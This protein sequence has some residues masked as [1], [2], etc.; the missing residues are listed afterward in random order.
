MACTYSSPAAAPGT[1]HEASAVSLCPA[2]TAPFTSGSFPPMRVVRRCSPL[3]LHLFT[4]NPS[5]GAASRRVNVLGM[6]ISR[7]QLMISALAL[8]ALGAIAMTP[9]LLGNRVASAIS[10]LGG[11]NQ[12][13]LLIPILGFV[14]PFVCTV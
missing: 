12:F 3:N 8:A 14:G 11:A 6:T 13:W 5:P 9:G 7:T 1:A 2:A 10:A 4:T